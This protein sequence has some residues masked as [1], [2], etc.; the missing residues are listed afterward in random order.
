[1]KDRLVPEW[2]R[3]HPRYEIGTPVLYRVEMPDAA[4]P[5]RTKR[6]RSRNLSA[7]GLLLEAEEYLPPGTRLALPLIR[8]KL[9]G[10]EGH[11]EVV[12]VKEPAA[13]N[14][15]LHGVQITRLN[16]LHH[17]VWRRFLQEASREIGRRSLRFDVDLRLT[18]RGKYGHDGCEGRTGNQSRTGL[19]VLLPVRF[20]E[21]SI[22]SLGIRTPGRTFE[23]EAR[24]VRLGDP[25]V[26]GRIPHGLVFVDLQEA[27][28]LLSEVLLVG[29]L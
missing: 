26:D 22:L 1:M 23:T 16:P 7:H 13:W 14:H 10:I 8:G 15:I 20:P 2:R 17:A 4:L 3:R 12:W 21:R 9:G 29:L 28:R 11:G 5:P 6:G 18:C 19:L 24:V 27:S 25:R